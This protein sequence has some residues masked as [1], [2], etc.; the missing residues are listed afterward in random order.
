M[1][2]EWYL[3]ACLGSLSLPWEPNANT[4]YLGQHRKLLAR[5]GKDK[6]SAEGGAM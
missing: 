4:G 5:N 2:A 1:W 6:P 3:C